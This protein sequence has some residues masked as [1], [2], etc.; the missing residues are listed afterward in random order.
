VARARRR[1]S[2]TE[3]KVT[4]CEADAQDLPFL[5]DQF[6]TVVFALCL[7][8]IPDDRRAVAEGVRVLKRGGRILM[9]EHVRS[10]LAIVRA[11]QH[12]VEP[13]SV[14]FQADHLLGEPT[15]HLRAEGMHIDEVR[16]WALSIMA[17]VFAHKPIVKGR[18]VREAKG[19][20]HGGENEKTPAG[21]SRPEAAPPHLGGLDS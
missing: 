5:A 15:D 9:L 13:L 20:R 1:A 8:S 18:M 14:R 21:R 2:Q 11:V 10:T 6:D 19:S 12:V 17:R 7:C 16:R 4:L 3:I